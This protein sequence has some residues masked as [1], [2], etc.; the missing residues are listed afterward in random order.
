M[1]CIPE[2]FESQKQAIKPITVSWAST[3]PRVRHMR[4]AQSFDP[5]A[6]TRPVGAQS[7]ASCIP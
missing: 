5:S 6:G 7:A 2:V 3:A 4:A 1:A